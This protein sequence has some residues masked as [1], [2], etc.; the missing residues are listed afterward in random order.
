MFSSKL[1]GTF[2]PF[3]AN[4][5][6]AR[7][8]PAPV[9]DDDELIEG[10]KL[11][12]GEN[13]KPGLQ[14]NDQEL[15]EEATSYR[16]KSCS[17]R[18]ARNTRLELLKTLQTSIED[19]IEADA[20]KRKLDPPNSREGTDPNVI[21]RDVDQAQK[22]PLQAGIQHREMRSNTKR[23]CMFDCTSQGCKATKREAQAILNI[24]GAVMPRSEVPDA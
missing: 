23:G 6:S 19:K 20:K 5:E 22:D 15:I 10:R 1:I 13:V 12:F 3:P 16:D 14:L 11:G 17:R 9:S 7:D 24:C 18:T 21:N 8:T 2:S 4:G